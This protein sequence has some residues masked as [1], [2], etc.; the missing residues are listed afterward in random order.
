M[1]Y[2]NAIYGLKIRKWFGLTSQLGGGVHNAATAFGLNSGIIST[3]VGPWIP[4]RPIKLHKFGVM[5]ETACDTEPPDADQNV[6]RLMAPNSASI[7]ATISITN[8]AVN[9]I[10]SKAIVAGVGIVEEGETVT[11]KISTALDSTNTDVASLCGGAVAFFID[12]SPHYSA[13]S[14]AAWID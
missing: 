14:E 1:A 12:Y 11:I 7:A 2:D 6:F 4:G 9:A 8:L 13:T 3:P 10:A 5:A